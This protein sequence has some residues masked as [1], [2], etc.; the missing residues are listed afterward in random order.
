M[1]FK[2]TSNLSFPQHQ[3]TLHLLQ[4][5]FSHC[6]PISA[7]PFPSGSAVLSLHPA[8]CS[9][10][11]T[12][13]PWPSVEKWVARCCYPLNSPGGHLAKTSWVLHFAAT[14]SQLPDW[15]KP[16]GSRKEYK[17]FK[18]HLSPD[19]DQHTVML[20]FHL[21]SNYPPEK[22]HFP[23]LSAFSAML[24][25]H[26]ASNP[27]PT[28]TATEMQHFQMQTYSKSTCFEQAQNLLC[29]FSLSSVVFA[30]LIY[31]VLVSCLVLLNIKAV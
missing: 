7:L 15:R 22:H 6:T 19:Q 31:L 11:H 3:K 2:L 16:P 8:L 20:P 27:S 9:D 1:I 26:K 21:N 4:G 29:G 14:D 23:S 5:S 13:F 28:C 12:S 24:E 18:S 25:Q 30:A 10:V 17:G